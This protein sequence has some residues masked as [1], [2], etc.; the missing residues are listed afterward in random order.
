MHSQAIDRDRPAI[1]IVRRIIY[2]HSKPP[3]RSF[4]DRL[5]Q[6]DQA[7]PF[8]TCPPGR[9]SLL[10]R[11]PSSKLKRMHRLLLHNEQILDTRENSLSAGQVGLLNGWGVFTTIRVHNGV[12]FAFERHWARMQRDA[13]LMRVPFPA[14]PRWLESR[15][16]SLVEANHAHNATLRM[17]I[18]R[19]RGGLFEGPAIARDF[20]LIAF[21]TGLKDWGTGAR[22]GVIPNGRFSAGVSSG[23]KILSWSQNLVWHEEAIANG[24]DEVLLLN[25][26]GEVSE[27]TSANL[28]LIA[29]DRLWTPPLSS[30]CLPG[31]TREL[32]L[33]EV[34]LAGMQAAEKLLTLHDFADADEVFM[35]SS[36]R[37]ILPVISI[38][39]IALR[40]G[41]QQTARWNTAFQDYLEKYSVTR[42][43]IMIETR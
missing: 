12:L 36:T 1:L 14:D 38:E 6:I 7:S 40:G 27:C 13:K 17:A 9:Q 28:F 30:G 39:G 42:P 3:E 4:G 2:V 22:L 15:L 16:L 26:R 32:L 18:V 21:T 35:T 29:G 41:G 11:H 33:S 5:E 23:A 19:N 31:I 10:K 34:R 24:Y 43:V 20:D 37:D 8:P 25:E